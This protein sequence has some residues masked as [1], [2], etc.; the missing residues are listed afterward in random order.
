MRVL[1][2]PKHF[3][4]SVKLQPIE[5]N[6]NKNEE[7]TITKSSN[8]IISS[9]VEQAESQKA[10]Y[11][12]NSTLLKMVIE[13]NQKNDLSSSLCMHLK[14][15]KAHAKLEDIKLKRCRISERLFIKEN[16]L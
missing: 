1:L 10:S 13:A 15:S 14:D 4:Q 8:S 16:K 3:E 7:S 2:S 9:A 11:L 12:Q 5:K 6:E